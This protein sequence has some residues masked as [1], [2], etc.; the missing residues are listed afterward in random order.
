MDKNE[1]IA[2]VYELGYHI[3][4]SV[5]EEKVPAEVDKIR[6]II[7]KKGGTFIAEDFPKLRQLAYTMVKKIGSANHRFNEAHFGWI[8][9]E[10]DPIA[11]KDIKSALDSS[12]SI[13]RYLLIETVRENTYLG[14]KAPLN[15]KGKDGAEASPVEAAGKVE[16][17]QPASVEEID[18]SIDD[19]V[20]EA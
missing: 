19:M 8:K 3:V 20:K 16:V 6:S 12:D 4:S 10:I 17:K 15:I 5:P 7:E 2:R 9:F 13:L 1:S 18:K 14:Q 11:L